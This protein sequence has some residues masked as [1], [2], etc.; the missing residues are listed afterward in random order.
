VSGVIKQ[1]AP[2]K[3]ARPA[4]VAASLWLL[5]AVLIRPGWPATIL[6]LSPLV[7][8][9]L[10]MYLAIGPVRPGLAAGLSASAAAAALSFVPEAGLV[11]CLL[12]I[13]WL[14]AAVLIATLGVVRVLS[15]RCLHPDI[16]VDFALIFLVVGAAWLTISRAGANPLG[17]SDTL[18]LLTAVHFHYA[19]FALPLVAGI[20]AAATGRSWK[21]PSL[22]VVGVP[23]TAIGITA[24]GILEWLSATF[25]ASAGL[26][27]ASVLWVYAKR[28]AGGWARGA[29]AAAAVALATGMSMALGWAWSTK[30][31]WRYLDVD[32][33]ART[34]GS[35]NALGFGLLAIFGL[36]HDKASGHHAPAFHL[37]RPT[38]LRLMDL[39]DAA[40]RCEPTS[41]VGLLSS[42]IPAGY[43]HDVWQTDLPHGFDAGC[44]ALRAWARQRTAD[45][46]VVPDDAPLV[47]GTTVAIAIPLWLVSI[48]ATCRIVDTVDEHDR[49]GFTYATLPHHPEDGEESFIVQRLADGTATYTVTAVW[50]SGMLCTRIFPPLTRRLQQHATAKYLTG[51]AAFELPTSKVTTRS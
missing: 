40:T 1:D 7:I 20:S 38:R 45:I 41:P 24:G 44:A 5:W 18:V 30:F 35:I 21:V 27:V 49:F 32:W 42:P 15:R 37:G 48:S 2:Y 8:V 13:P 50:R 4:F 29:L 6:L 9:P 26:V 3:S 51:V 43:H 12:T 25:M 17:F 19:G 34:H 46:T 39:R 36:V 23:F 10:G 14:L 31:A 22:V 47:N 28:V 16:G 33:M 11:A